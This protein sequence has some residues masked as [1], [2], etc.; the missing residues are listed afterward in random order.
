MLV[1]RIAEIDAS[2]KNITKIIVFDKTMKGQDI[3]MLIEEFDYGQELIDK[4]VSIYRN[5]ALVMNLVKTKEELLTE[6]KPFL[7]KHFP[8]KAVVSKL[9]NVFM[10]KSYN[11]LL[12]ITNRRLVTVDVKKL[13][14]KIARTNNDI[15]Y[16]NETL[17]KEMP[18][19]EE[20]RTFKDVIKGIFR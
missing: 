19:E 17:E 1:S 18:K 11:K 4:S 8:K 12:L 10:N 14:E 2:N 3:K 20:K 5:V 6:W 9:D 15:D 7:E 16:Y 13:N